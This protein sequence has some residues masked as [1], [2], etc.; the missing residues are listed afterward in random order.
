VG[1]VQISTAL[2]SFWRFP[3]NSTGLRT[4]VFIYLLFIFWFITLSF[5][6]YLFIFF[7]ISKVASYASINLSTK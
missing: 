7:Q 3:I 2:D 1:F 4:S 5:K 6:F